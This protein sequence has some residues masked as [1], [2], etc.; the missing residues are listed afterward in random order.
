[1]VNFLSAG[2]FTAANEPVSRFGPI[3]DF[4]PFYTL[5]L[6]IPTLLNLSACRLRLFKRWIALSIG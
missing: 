6:V 2:F 5:K 3:E 1:M 4:L